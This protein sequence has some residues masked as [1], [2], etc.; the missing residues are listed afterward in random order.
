M[1]PE[2]DIAT[3]EVEA[4]APAPVTEATVE[5]A[6][7]AP[8]ESVV[9]PAESPEV[10]ETPEAA[11][12][13]P[14]VAQDEVEP[15]PQ[16]K[17]AKFGELELS[18]P[19]KLPSTILFDLTTLELAGDDPM[20]AYRLLQSMLGME[21]FIHVRNIVAQ[22]EGEDDGSSVGELLN[23]IFDQYGLSLGE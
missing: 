9:E 18:L 7:V 10:E 21:Q 1:P 3:S 23:A 22:E 8:V 6:P 15:E 5:A 12:P 11:S 13:V 17:T 4:V 19:D 20:P 14:E 2:N 16:P